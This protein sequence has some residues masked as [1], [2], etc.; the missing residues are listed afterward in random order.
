MSEAAPAAVVREMTKREQLISRIKS[1]WVRLRRKLP[2]IVWY[3]D[4]L[5]V[6]VTLTK[7]KLDPDKDGMRQLFSGAF[8]DA[9][10]IFHE[11]GISF[12]TG[13]GCAGRDWE[14]DW[15]LNGPI[16]VRFRARATKPELRR[17]RFKP[18]LVYSDNT[19]PAA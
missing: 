2:Y 16:S 3:D 13:M 15:S 1:Y 18:T 6:T 5:D 11:M 4:E 9:E 7:D 14:W 10:R 8:S 19:R 17:E 12:D